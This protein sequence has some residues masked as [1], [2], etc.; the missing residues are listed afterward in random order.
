MVGEPPPPPT[1]KVSDVINTLARSDTQTNRGP[2][3]RETTYSQLLSFHGISSQSHQNLH[4]DYDP[5]ELLFIL[6]TDDG[7]DQDKTPF[8][9][10]YDAAHAFASNPYD[11]WSSKSKDGSKRIEKTT[12]TLAGARETRLQRARLIVYG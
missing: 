3:E 9:V 4:P 5:P 11:A 1:T 10:I 2:R 7:P 12:V 6:P 8:F